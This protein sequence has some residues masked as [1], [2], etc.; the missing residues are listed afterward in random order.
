MCRVPSGMYVTVWHAVCVHV[1]HMHVLVILGM[2]MQDVMREH[3][4]SQC[5]MEQEQPFRTRIKLASYS[6]V[7]MVCQHAVRM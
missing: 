2:F 3:G 1:L 5:K 6:S 4:M 7:I